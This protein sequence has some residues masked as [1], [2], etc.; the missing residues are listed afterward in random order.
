[1]R[2]DT[3]IT[4]REDMIDSREIIDRIDYLQDER[5]TLESAVEEAQ[6]GMDEVGP[7]T[8]ALKD[9][10]EALK[11]W[12][13]SDEGQE[14]KALK[15]LQNEAD[16]YSEDWRHGSTLIRDTY[17]TE[18][19]EQLAS[20]VTEYNPN[21]VSWPFTCIDWEKA[22]DELKQDYT[23]VDFDGVDYWTR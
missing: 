2:G 8:E 19:A 21:K 12:D 7:T 10:Q 3:E 5:S 14:L 9:A 23:S 17:F 6:E 15:A 22:A 16:G 13:E 18:Y 11:E 4:N 1:M 20:E